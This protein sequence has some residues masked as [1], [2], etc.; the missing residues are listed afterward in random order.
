MR[1]LRLCCFLGGF[2]GIFWGVGGVVGCPGI[3][4]QRTCLDPLRCLWAG[5]LLWNLPWHCLASAFISNSGSGLK[6]LE[7]LLW[8]GV[9]SL[10][11]CFFPFLCALSKQPRSLL[12]HVL[13]SHPLHLCWEPGGVEWWVLVH[14][15]LVMTSPSALPTVAINL[16]V[17]HIQDILNG[18]VSK[19]QSNGCLNGYAPAR[20]R[21]ASES[22]SRPH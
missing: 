16:I 7:D 10:D 9:L 12:V 4:Q 13:S 18:G 8:V 11:S 19:R 22:S 15:H 3:T 2:S 5:T 1:L 6:Q 21:Q 20:K 17:Q 14:H